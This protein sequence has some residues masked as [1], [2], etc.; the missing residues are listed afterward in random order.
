MYLYLYDSFLNE[1]RYGSLVAKIETRLTDLGVGGKI[2]RLSPLRNIEELL[3]DE[4]KNGIKTVVAV[5]NDKTV[6][7]VINVAA[8]FNITMGIIPVGPDNKIAQM[9]GIPSPEEACNILAGRIVERIDLGKANDTFFLSSITLSSEGVTIECED[10][11]RLTTQAQDQVSIC[12]FKPLLASNL[13]QTNYF[14]PKDGLLEILV[15][16]IASGFFNFFKKTT[17]LNSSIIPFKKIFIR[18]SQSVP[19][20]TDGQKVLKTPVQIEIVPKKLQIIVG[21]NRLF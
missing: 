11:Y 3:R 8:R 16:P 2:F 12:N 19:I 4:V 20:F 6:S 13:G 18:S 14:N 1:K 5:G 17:S 10:Q 7:Q 9:L 15:Q 21:K